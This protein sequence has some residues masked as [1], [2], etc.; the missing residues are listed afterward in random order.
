[1]GLR[2]RIG[3]LFWLLIGIIVSLASIRLGIGR[4]ANPG[5]GFMPFFS[6]LLLIFLSLLLVVQEIRKV[7]A[8]PSISFSLNINK[9]L[10]ILVCSFLVFI[11]V[12]QTLGYLI[13]LSI[14]L[15]VLLEA[16]APKKWIS[17]LLWA[18][19]VSIC[20]YLIFSILLKCNLPRGIF[21]LG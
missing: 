21:N 7:R 12:L 11:F 10:G 6:G 4:A 19:G 15:F 13:S 20:S 1:M 3:I 2:E 18:I 16:T 14:L 9:N 5:S 8:K 17:S